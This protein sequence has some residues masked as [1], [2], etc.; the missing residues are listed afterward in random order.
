MKEPLLKSI[1]S[2]FF[3]SAL[4]SLFSKANTEYK[5]ESASCAVIWYSI[6]LGYH[7]STWPSSKD[8]L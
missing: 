4:C 1:L 7:H 5:P 3:S 6:S 2:D 8:C